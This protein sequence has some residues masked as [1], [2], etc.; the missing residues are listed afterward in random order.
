MVH[1]YL[2]WLIFLLF[3]M[4]L[5]LCLQR[6]MQRARRVSHSDERVVFWTVMSFD[7][8]LV[9]GILL[10]I[11]GHKGLQL[12]QEYGMATVMS[13]KVMRFTVVEHPAGMIIA[14][15]LLH[16]GKVKL[17]KGT[18]ANVL[19]RGH[20]PYKIMFVLTLIALLVV[21]MSIPWPWREAIGRPLFLIGMPWPN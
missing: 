15:I 21:V 17:S 1:S 6:W 9:L 2:R 16:I 7:L 20:K 13:S 4:T 11:F 14:T 19:P 18:N 10:W 8:M 12:I 3:I 5:F